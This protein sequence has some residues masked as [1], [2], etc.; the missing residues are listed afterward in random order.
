MVIIDRYFIVVVIGDIKIV[1]FTMM[2]KTI[3]MMIIIGVIEHS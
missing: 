1:D 2:S 3:I